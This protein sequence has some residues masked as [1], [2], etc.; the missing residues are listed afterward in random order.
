MSK[1]TS[2]GELIANG[3]FDAGFTGWTVEA[4]GTQQP[5]ISDGYAVLATS[6]SISQIVNVAADTELTLSYDFALVNSATGHVEVQSHP[7]G[8]Y[9]VQDRAPKD[10][11]GLTFTVPEGD[12]SVEVTFACD[13]GGEAHVDNVSLLQKLGELIIGGDFSDASLPGWTAAAS[14]SETATVVDNHLQMPDGTSVYQDVTVTAGCTLSLSYSMQ[15]LYG[16]QGNVTVTAQTSGDQLYYD[17]VGGTI[18]AADFIVPEGE[19]TV[20]I[21]FICTLGGEIDVDNVSMTYV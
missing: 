2:C 1:L 16:A 4:G 21:M 10:E 15:L 20:R 12:N 14:T 19:N 18:T 3:T 13:I 11:P 6:D 9:L 17:N 7:S 8:T 5:S